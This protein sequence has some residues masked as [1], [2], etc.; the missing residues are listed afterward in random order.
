M[1]IW[2]LIPLYH[3]IERVVFRLNIQLIHC[4]PSNPLSSKSCTINCIHDKGTCGVLLGPTRC[5]NIK[6]AVNNAVNNSEQGREQCSEHRHFKMNHVKWHHAAS[7]NQLLIHPVIFK[8]SSLCLAL[9]NRKRKYHNYYC[10][11]E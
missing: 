7:R 9:I 11:L 6:D 1:F 8:H 2:G 5:K 10:D 4:H 3:W